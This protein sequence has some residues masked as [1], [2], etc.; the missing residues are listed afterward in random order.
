MNTNID[1]TFADA[2]IINTFPNN[3]KV[4]EIVDEIKENDID[5]TIVAY[6]VY[7]SF[8]DYIVNDSLIR[9]KFCMTIFFIIVGALFII[10]LTKLI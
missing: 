5:E 9:Y 6:V 7:D 2:Y 1:E 10:L 8:H 4:A 3:V